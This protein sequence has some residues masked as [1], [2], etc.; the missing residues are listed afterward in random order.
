MGS[1]KEHLSK[2]IS[3]IEVNFPNDER[4]GWIDFDNKAI[5]YNSGHKFV[6]CVEK[7][8]GVYYYNLLRIIF[9]IMIINK[10]DHTQMDAVKTFEIFN[11]LLHEVWR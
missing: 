8:K 6:K 3:I 1:N 2:G 9:I 4:E 11:K 10:N 7:Y 5:A